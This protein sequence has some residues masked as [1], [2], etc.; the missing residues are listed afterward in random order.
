MPDYKSMY[1]HL[2]GRMATTIEVL[3]YATNTLAGTSEELLALTEKLKL[4]QQNT[5]DMFICG[6]DEEAADGKSE[7]TE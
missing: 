6:A 5:E 3:E 4:A 7:E 2:A 1:Y